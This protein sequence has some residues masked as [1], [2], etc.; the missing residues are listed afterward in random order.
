M[1]VCMYGW[2]YMLWIYVMD[3]C[4]YVCMYVCISTY[5][6]S[7][8]NI[9]VHAGELVMASSLHGHISRTG[10]RSQSNGD[11]VLSLPVCWPLLGHHRS[12]QGGDGVEESEWESRGEEES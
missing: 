1:D 10:P 11:G 12:Y 3:V 6:I 9:S 5:N 7:V 4:M 8:Y 2:I